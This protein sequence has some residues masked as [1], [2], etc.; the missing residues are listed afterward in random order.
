MRKTGAAREESL[1]EHDVYW[2]AA[3]ICLGIDRALDTDMQMRFIAGA[4]I[5]DFAKADT[6]LDALARGHR[7]RPL[8]QVREQDIVSV[9]PH[10]DMIARH[11]REI[12]LARGLINHPITRH[13]D[14][15]VA[16]RDHLG[17][18]YAIGAGGP[19]RRLKQIWRAGA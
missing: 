10:D 7:Y 12:G 5:A 4:G 19:R 17:A 1:V 18:E 3:E 16:G 15:A 2:L 13:H 9:A 6:G 14:F 11:E 8:P